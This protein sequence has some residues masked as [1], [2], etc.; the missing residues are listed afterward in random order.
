[1]KQEIL[2]QLHTGHQGIPKT[3]RLARNTVY[4]PNINKDIEKICKSCATC[5]EY[6]DRNCKEPLQPYPVPSRPWQSISSDLFSI[7]DKSFLLIVDRYSRYPLVV[8]FK[9]VPSSRAVTE[10]MK[11][12]CA[13]LGCPDSIASDNGTQYTGAAY[14]AFVAQW[15]IKHITSSPNYP[16][17]NGLAERHVRHVKGLIK[18]SLKNNQD[19]Q[20]VLMN[21]RATLINRELPSP[22]EMLTG[23]PMATLLPSRGDP[24]PSMQRKHLENLSTQMKTYHD[25][26]SRIEDLPPLYKAQSI[27]ILDKVN[28]T[29]CP[30]IVV[31]KAPEPRS[32]VVQTPSGTKVRRNR[33]HLQ[34]MMV[35]KL[36]L[37]SDEA[38]KPDTP[39]IP[40]RAPSLP[41]RDYS[42][43][44]YKDKP[45]GAS[46]VK[47]QRSNHT[48][49]TP[50]Q[51][52]KW[53]PETNSQK[54]LFH[55]F[56][57]DIEMDATM[58]INFAMFSHELI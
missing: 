48:T 7:R 28:K 2:M 56:K 51:Y 19:L 58:N 24:G 6:Q 34:P 32:Y 8:E 45:P 29:W 50:I 54:H 14:Q 30:G 18:K 9:T 37:V 13:M 57:W 39:E 33:S 52:R 46:P 53:A 1:M 20:V 15:G 17:S 5:Q 21:I 41:T 35:P 31:D 10:A 43:R 22:A 40:S 11:H 27:R 55:N 49:R 38:P 3:Q 16:R 12:Y 23:R 26:T 36:P 25:K 4:W 47:L 42:A 44:D